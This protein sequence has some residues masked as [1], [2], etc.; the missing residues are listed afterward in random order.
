MDS[1]SPRPSLRS[2][3][4]CHRTRSDSTNPARPRRPSTRATSVRAAL[5]APFRA[6]ANRIEHGPV[7]PP[8]LREILAHLLASLL[9]QFL[10]AGSVH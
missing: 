5:A 1:V 3:P 4:P 8:F 7:L 2:R 9:V 10:L 6:T